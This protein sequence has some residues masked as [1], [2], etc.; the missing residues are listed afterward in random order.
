VATFVLVH[1]GGHGGWCWGPLARRLRDAGHD[2]HTPTLTGLGERAHLLT[3][4]IDLDTHVT[5]VAGVLFHEDL[6]DVV[7]VGHSY[8]GTVVTGVADRSP[9]RLRALVYL[10]AARPRDGQSTL[11]LLGNP[12][13]E[14]AGGRIVDGVELF[15]FPDGAAPQH[16]GVTDP[17]V[18]AWMAP[19][20]T[21]HPWRSFAQPLRLTGAGDRVPRYHIACRGAPAP[22]RVWVL[23]AGHDLMLTATDDVA[24]IL[25]SI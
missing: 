22:G 10:D 5:D 24:E 3:P 8:G 4:E 1:G 25:Q 17:A 7:L 16:Y 19:R 21:P 9:D 14:Q 12:T 20:L 2:V 18:A 6:H 15:L 13:F 11:D 23:D